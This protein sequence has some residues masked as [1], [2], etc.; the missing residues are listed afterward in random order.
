MTNDD[1]KNPSRTKLPPLA[2]REDP[3]VCENHPLRIGV[4]ILHYNKLDLTAACCESVLEQR[5]PPA[6]VVVVDN[7]SPEHAPEA[8]PAACPPGVECLRTERN[9]GFSGANN[10]GIRHLLDDQSI[11]A[12]L[13]LNNDTRCPPDL[14]RAMAAA[15]RPGVGLVGCEMVGAGGGE[16][17]A[18]GGAFVPFFAYPVR[19]RPGTKPDYLQGSCLLAPRAALERVGLL[20]DTFEFFFEDADWSLRMQRAGY[21]LA[22]AEG[23]KLLHYGSATI[24][25]LGRQQSSWYR[26][27]HIVFLRKWRSYPFARAV[28]PFLFRLAIDVLRGRREAVLG[29]L[30][31]WRAGWRRA[32]ASACRSHA[33][34]SANSAPSA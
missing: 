21:E 16:A 7:G 20:D 4:V 6:R 26:A 9:L 24:G 34:S 18:A 23:V 17:Q 3:G 27:S 10:L 15:L 25:A 31:G 33:A 32:L 19:L 28:G 22:V 30:E 1:G 8:L 2:P 13:L 29:T 11:D 12:V 5:D 14:T